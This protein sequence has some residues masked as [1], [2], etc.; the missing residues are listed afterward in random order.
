MPHLTK[1]KS[2]VSR[3]RKNKFKIRNNTF[4]IKVFGSVE[5]LKGLCPTKIHYIV[6]F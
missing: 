4:E 5:N 3:R 6:V 2:H 1:L